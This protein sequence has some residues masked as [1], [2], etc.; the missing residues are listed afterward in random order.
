MNSI[1]VR[2]YTCV[3]LPLL[4]LQAGVDDQRG[5]VAE[6]EQAV[7]LDGPVDLR[8]EDHHLNDNNNKKVGKNKKGH[9]DRTEAIRFQISS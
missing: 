2:V 1:L 5:E 8:A 6:V 3:A 9:K 4:L 7:Q